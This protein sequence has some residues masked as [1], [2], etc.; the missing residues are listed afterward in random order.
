[1]TFDEEDISGLETRKTF[2]RNLIGVTSFSGKQISIPKYDFFPPYFERP[3]NFDV[4]W[5]ESSQES[6]TTIPEGNIKSFIDKYKPKSYVDLIS[7]EKA[8]REVLNWLRQFKSSESLRKPKGSKKKRKSRK[9]EAAE[10]AAEDGKG[11]RTSHVLILAGPPGSGKSTLVQVIAAHCNYH[12][13]ELNASEDMKNERNQILLTNQLDFQP[14]FGKKTKPLLVL[15]E[16]DGVGTMNDTVLKNVMSLTE[17]PVVIIVNNLYAPALRYIRTQATI[18]RMDHPP[19]EKIVLRL[20]RIADSEGINY[21]P[22]AISNIAK[23]S[24]YDMRTALNTLQFLAI[25]QP[26]TSE[27][28]QLMPVGV[29]NATFTY[30]DIMTQLFTMSSKLEDSLLALEAFGD[31]QLVSTGILEN[32]E[33]VKAGG[34]ANRR[35][36]DVL[37]NLSFADT[38]YGEIAQ[39]GLACVPKLVGVSHINRQIIYPTDTFTYENTIKKNMKL[40]VG[41]FKECSPLISVYMNPDQQVINSL[42]MRGNEDLRDEFV[43]FHKY[44]KI[45]YTKSISGFY[46]SEPEIDTFLTYNQNFG[47]NNYN[48]SSSSKLSKFREFIQREMDKDKVQVTKSSAKGTSGM[49]IED[50]LNRKKMDSRSLKSRD[51]W[52]NVVD[53]GPSQ[54]SQ[55]RRPTMY[56]RYNEGYTN[57]VKRVVKHNRIFGS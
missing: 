17:R 5:V 47:R 42:F 41:R 33:T 37:D 24:K 55:D 13:I 12:V 8:N 57:A 52:G 19:T 16:M 29:K 21:V 14:V 31:N 35:I 15:E 36:A 7:E 28:V 53:I 40:F 51:F 54:L 22:Q 50:R 48:Y 44:L 34:Y 32:I 46:N 38:A 9:Q 6:Q 27:M 18:V 2:L 25:R 3:Y 26:I 43:N 11:L 1:M 39:L 45:S 30:F 23:Q 56:F 49:R 4:S 10:T 20:K